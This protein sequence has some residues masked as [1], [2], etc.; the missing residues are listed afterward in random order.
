MP[1][2]AQLT[3]SGSAWFHCHLRLAAARFRARRPEVPAAR[4]STSWT[5]PARSSTAEA[6]APARST[7]PPEPRF[8][9]RC[10]SLSG[11]ELLHEIVETDHLRRQVDLTQNRHVSASRIDLCL[12]VRMQ[13]VQV[14]NHA[15]RRVVQ[16]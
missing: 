2:Q 15:L 13:P 11:T 3:S 16:I 12:Q 4:S 14:E 6:A 7:P 5:A 10:G 8:L 1:R 9:E